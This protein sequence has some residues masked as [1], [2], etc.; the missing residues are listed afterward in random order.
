MLP[1]YCARIRLLSLA[2]PGVSKNVADDS[3]AW[4]LPEHLYMLCLLSSCVRPVSSEQL[5]LRLLTVVVMVTPLP[6]ASTSAVS[7]SA[8]SVQSSGELRT[9][10]LPLLFWPAAFAQ[11]PAFWGFT[12]PVFFVPPARPVL[13]GAYATLVFFEASTRPV[14]F[15]ASTRPV[16]LEASVR[17]VFSFSFFLFSFIL[18]FIYLFFVGGAYMLSSS[19]FSPPSGCKRVVWAQFPRCFK[20]RCEDPTEVSGGVT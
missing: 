18:L 5:L 20:G 14:F 16:F 4:H 3:L 17:P 15:G 8:T 11:P 9:G 12:C 13:F 2:R 19:F 6:S 1:Y 10:G 7:P